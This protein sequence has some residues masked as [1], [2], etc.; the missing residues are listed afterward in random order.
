MHIWHFFHDETLFE[1][2]WKFRKSVL[3]Y[4]HLSWWKLHRWKITQYWIG[5]I[6]LS[7]RK[8]QQTVYKSNFYIGY[9]IGRYTVAKMKSENCNETGMYRKRFSTISDRN[10]SCSQS[11]SLSSYFGWDR[12]LLTPIIVN[13][14]SVAELEW[15]DI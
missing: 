15:N 13:I 6:D 1:F 4:T 11:F 9:V 12:F 7:F 3:Y 2:F 5:W 10:L 8:F 14:V